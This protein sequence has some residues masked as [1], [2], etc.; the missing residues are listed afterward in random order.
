MTSIDTRPVLWRLSLAVLLW[1]ISHALSA[2]SVLPPAMVATLFLISGV[3]LVHPA[4]ELILVA[5]ER[6]ARKLNWSRFTT[7]SLLE[8]L[9]SLPEI[10]VLLFIAVVSP[11]AA[12]T[13]ALLTVYKHALVFSLYSWF[14][15]HDEHG[16][17]QMPRPI[18]EAGTQVMTAA[19]AL[20]LIAGVTMLAM[21]A[22]AHHKTGLAAV[23]LIA[24]SVILLLIFAAYIGRLTVEYAHDELEAPVMAGSAH[25]TAAHVAFPWRG[26][27]GLVILG[28]GGS[29]LAGESAL[30]FAG[31]AL[32]GLQLSELHT[33][34]LMIG[35]GGMGEYVL[36]YKTH[37]RREYGIAL[38][39]TFGGIVK[40]LYLVLPVTLLS[41]ALVW[42]LQPPDTILLPFSLG[43][44]LLLLFLF[45]VFYVFANLLEESHS[46]N[47]LDTTIMTGIVALLVM[48]LLSYG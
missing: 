3:L 36:V 33:A 32:G 22:T 10:I 25:S 14:L 27:V 41:I 43:N 21:N 13:L 1:L 31:L 28:L 7:V 23:D 11:Q 18:T 48:F 40:V 46:L 19:G 15:P 35:F 26:I 5:I 42:L 47:A 6:S 30:S 24:I 8:V 45:P 39:H 29:F 20:G 44:M 9:A 4:T 37:R 38:A 17:Y 12:F 16:E 34:L 2:S